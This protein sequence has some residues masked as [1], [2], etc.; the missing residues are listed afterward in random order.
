MTINLPLEKGRKIQ[1]EAARLL[2]S[3]LI[4]AQHLAIFIG[5][6]VTTSRAVMQAPLHYRALQRTLNSATS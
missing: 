2:K 5:K 1:Q 3:Q 4:S 6:A